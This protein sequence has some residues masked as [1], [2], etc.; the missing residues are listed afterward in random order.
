MCLPLP[1]RQQG[2]EKA[3]GLQW[4]KPCPSHQPQPV[5]VFASEIWKA[6]NSGKETRRQE[7]AV[8]NQVSGLGV[9]VV[10]VCV[11]VCVRR[12][13]GSFVRQVEPASL[14]AERDLITAV[15]R[16]AAWSAHTTELH[17][18][19]C[20]VPGKVPAPVQGPQHTTHAQNI[21]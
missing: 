4:Q 6:G 10:V 1:G 2:G 12:Q 17:A 15:G 20:L 14:C 8:K 19:G 16:E 9:C 11:C 13:R 18:H 7:A 3:R 21:I 5:F